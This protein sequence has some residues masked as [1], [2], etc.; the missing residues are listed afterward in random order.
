MNVADV[1]QMLA[2]V[3]MFGAVNWVATEIVV[4]SVIFK[5]IREKV[6]TWGN[7]VK[8]RYP[9]TGEKISYFLTCALC[10]GVWIGFIE[11]AVFGGPLHTDIP[12]L[13]WSMFVANG[14]AYKA[15]GH[16]LLQINGWFH[17]RNELMKQQVALVVR[18]QDVCCRELE[19]LGTGVESRETSH[20]TARV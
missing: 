8:V 18:E 16:L 10:V 9:R 6:G 1:L 5:D 13:S 15:V 20:V 2:Y 19:L 4:N 7:R 3:L 12:W 17:N 11:A 14:L